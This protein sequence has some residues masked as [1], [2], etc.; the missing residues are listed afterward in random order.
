MIPVFQATIKGAAPI[1][2]DQTCVAFDK[3]CKTLEGR[4]VEVVVREAKARRSNNQNAY[5]WGV[6]IKLLQE[7]TGYH[8]SDGADELHEILRV[9]FLTVHTKFGDRV[10]ETSTLN[11]K[12]FEDY[13][14]QIRNWA[15][16]MF[17]V[18]NDAGEI[19]P[20][21]IPL[22]NEVQTGEQYE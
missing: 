1:F 21:M 14:D 11:T 22:P 4:R 3:Y 15:A 10:R 13:L 7:H 12:E 18:Q 5:Y 8:G 20:F 2:D 9:K 19:V 6:V 17:S 16:V